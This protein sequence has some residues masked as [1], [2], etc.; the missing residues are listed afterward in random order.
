MADTSTP[1]EPVEAQPPLWKAIW[2]PRML[3]CVFLG[4]SSGLPLWY[5]W[6]LIPYWLRT[7]DLS[8]TSIG[9]FS[10]V[11]LPFTW[12]F[13][14][15]PLLDRYA[16]PG[17]G[18][19]RGWMFVAQIALMVLIGAMG[20]FNPVQSLWSIAYLSV[21][22]ACAGAIQDIAIDAY[23]RELLPENELGLGSAIHINAYRISGFVSFSLAVFLSKDLD[24]SLVH[25]FVAAFM[26]PGALCSLFVKEPEIYGTPPNTIW[27]AVV[28][29]FWEFYERGGLRAAFYVL[30]FM[31][32]YKFGDTLA[33]ALI[34]PF[35]Y[36]MGFSEEQIAFV[37]KTIAV[38][39]FVAGGF[40][41]GIIIYRIGINRSLWIFGFMQLF[42]IFGLSFL[43]TQGNNVWVLA[44]AVGFEYLGMGLGGAAFVAYQ[45]RESDMRFTA[46]QLSLFTSLMAIPRLL[47]GPLAGILIEGNEA[48]G[49]PAL[50][51]PHFF[52][53]CA[54][55]AVPG[56]LLLFKVAPWNE[57]VKPAE[58]AD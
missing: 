40:L 48:M 42:S 27:E 54:V 1:D 15:A 26:L 18:R 24:W 37:T 33:T 47:T 38:V 53:F 17:L 50:G 3:I 29:P 20:F 52:L 39:S 21:A 49:V 30:A 5:L 4:F 51:Y 28:E 9:M 6:Q 25:L 34:T 22:I 57:P 31:L 46:T 36:D 2:N 41:G 45:A 13:L 55:A 12:K 16:V 43:A 19:R 23:R 56:M 44:W 35:Y 8:L 7:N 10:L 14:V 11:Q 58:P 32:L